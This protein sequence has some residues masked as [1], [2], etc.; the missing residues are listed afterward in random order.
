[1]NSRLKKSI[2]VLQRAY[3]TETL[4]A[5]NCDA[6]AVGN[7]VE[8]SSYPN[9][10]SDWRY[11]FCTDLRDDIGGPHQTFYDKPTDCEELQYELDLYNMGLCAVAATGYSVKELARIEFAFESAIEPELDEHMPIHKSQWIRLQAVLKVLFDIEGIPYDQEVEQP[12]L[13]KASA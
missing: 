12:F 13:E 6:C 8:A 3:L 9:A 5:G 10:P 4:K 2:E 7:L 1:M 11:I